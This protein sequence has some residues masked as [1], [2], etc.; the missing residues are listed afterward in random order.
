MVLLSVLGSGMINISIYSSC[1]EY[2]AALTPDIGE[3]LSSGMVNGLA[4]FLG[5]L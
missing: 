2:V 4:N 3:S 1:F 5:F